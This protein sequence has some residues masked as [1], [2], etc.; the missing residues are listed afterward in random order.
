[1]MWSW[2]TLETNR[3]R[4]SENERTFSKW[5]GR[6]TVKRFWTLVMVS[7]LLLT[8]CT[9]PPAATVSIDATDGPP[10]T[11]TDA[12]STTTDAWD[13]TTDAWDAPTDAWNTTTDAWG[14]TVDEDG[15][16]DP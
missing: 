3:C 2:P 15:F 13:T 12:W 14:S 6:T 10:S 16:G 5:K 9:P 1:M 7:A 8:G 11:T 4:D